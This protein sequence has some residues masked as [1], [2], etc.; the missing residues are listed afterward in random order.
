MQKKQEKKQNKKLIQQKLDC[1]K[2]ELKDNLI[3]PM[4]LFFI[5]FN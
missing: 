2:E 3:K 4:Y 1:E 5:N